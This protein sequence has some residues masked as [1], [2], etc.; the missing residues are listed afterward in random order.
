[1]SRLDEFLGTPR[2][3]I[4][5]CSSLGLASSYLIASV[6]FI[7][8]SVG[9]GALQISCLPDAESSCPEIW[10]FAEPLSHATRWG[11]FLGAWAGL[12]AFCY[13]YV[14]RWS[15]LETWKEALISAAISAAG[16]AALQARPEHA[17]KVFLLVLIAGFT[18]NA[19]GLVARRR[20]GLLER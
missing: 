13:G 17:W 10:S 6:T 11:L 4:A 16:F 7:P 19:A 14:G 12:I 1:L 3:R 8:L 5:F 9:F 18:G 20:A 15:R 2:R